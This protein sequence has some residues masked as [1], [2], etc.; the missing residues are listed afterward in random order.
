MAWPSKIYVATVNLGVYYTDDFSD[1][2]IQPTW[3]A[4]NTGL[5]ATDCREFWLDPFDNVN[6]QFVLLEASKTLYRRVNGG[7]WATILTP[8]QVRAIIGGD[9]GDVYGFCPDP[10]IIGR[11]WALVRYDETGAPTGCAACSLR[12]D[13]YGDTWVSTATIYYNSWG[14]LYDLGSI[15][16]YG[17]HI[18]VSLNT[19]AGGS[20][21]VFYSTNTGV[22]W[23]YVQ[24]D[25]AGTITPLSLN[26][27]LP[28]QVYVYNW[29]TDDLVLVT[30]IGG[31]STL[32]VDIGSNNW[33]SM[34][35]H[36][37]DSDHQ[38]IVSDSRLRVTIDAWANKSDAGVIVPAPY[39]IAPWSGV[40]IDQMLVGLNIV[41]LTNDHVIGALYGEADTTATGIAGTNCA[42]SPFTDSIPYTCGGLA[43][44]G[45]QAVQ[46]AIGVV[47]TYAVAM[48]EYTGQDRGIP[49]NGD[50]SAWDAL[51][52]QTRHANDINNPTGIHWTL[53]GLGDSLIPDSVD[54]ASDGADITAVN[55]TEQG[56]APLTPGAGHRIIY[57]KDDGIYER[58][59]GGIEI[60]PFGIGGAEFNDA[61][62]NPVDVDATASA[63]GT[64]DY[65]A[66]RDHR[67][68]LNATVGGQYRQFLYE[69]SGG[70]FTFLTDIDGNP[71]EGLQDLE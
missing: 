48:P 47:H 28:D 53:D 19:G 56:S 1:P 23:S 3:T 49:M 52:Y 7:N 18:Y 20:T 29:T 50:R 41:H 14:Y 24:V 45:I 21:K 58:N 37:T 16:A 26:P 69:V 44:M 55:F 71:L 65:A 35:F 62:G 64:S 36:L 31:L 6:R 61:E 30:N 67:H 4:I 2:A 59:D 34:W 63:D 66:R 13:D 25:I 38:R 27:L 46:A 10:T 5:A 54:I 33:A 57:A 22:N 17:E 9:N 12:S 60:G 42:A 40:D 32:Q 68:H 15:R 51:N 39:L 8:A 11:L 70:T 43:K